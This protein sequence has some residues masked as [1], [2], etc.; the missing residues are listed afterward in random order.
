MH[1]RI[2]I[3]LRTYIH[4]YIILSIPVVHTYIQSHIHACNCQSH[5]VLHAEGD[6]EL[7]LAALHHGYALRGKLLQAGWSAYTSK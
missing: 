3:N 6:K 2:Y 5:L 4:A 7:E 1:V